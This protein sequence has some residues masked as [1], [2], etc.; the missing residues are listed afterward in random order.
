MVYIAKMTVRAAHIQQLAANEPGTAP[1]AACLGADIQRA[2]AVTLA[3]T[4]VFLLAR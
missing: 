1:T 2:H 4:T 3:N